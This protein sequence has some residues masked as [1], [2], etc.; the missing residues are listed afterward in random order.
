MRFSWL[1]I[2]A[3]AAPEAADADDE[4]TRPEDGGA[5]YF[6]AP[7]GKDI[8]LEIPGER[9]TQNIALC[10]GVAGGGALLVGLGV[11]YNLD[12]RSAADAV[13]AHEATGRAWT[14]ADQS[15]LTR[16][17]DSGVKAGILYGVGGAMVIGAVVT[18]IVTEPKTEKRII[19]PHGT[20][21]AAPPAVSLAPTPGGALVAGRWSF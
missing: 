14:A 7:T 17:H 8:V 1:V 20:G 15:D 18:W 12:S 16:A 6:P 9:S 5:D 19:H 21:K 4:P 2:A 10:A 13:S 3:L 11:Y